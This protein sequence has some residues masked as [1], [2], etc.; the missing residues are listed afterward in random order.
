MTRPVGGDD[1]GNFY[2]SDSNKNIQDPAKIIM[3]IEDILQ[4]KLHH[5]QITK[6]EFTSLSQRLEGIQEQYKG[7]EAKEYE[8]NS[9]IVAALNQ[10]KSDIATISGDNTGMTST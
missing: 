4:Q 9:K 10:L 3:E 6:P 5:G 7:N 8:A 2:S 1:R